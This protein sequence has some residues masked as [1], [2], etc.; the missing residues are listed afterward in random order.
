MIR[1]VVHR[2]VGNVLTTAWSGSILVPLSVI[3]HRRQGTSLSRAYLGKWDGSNSFLRPFVVRMSREGSFPKTSFSDYKVFLQDY[4]AV[5]F[6]DYELDKEN[7]KDAK[8]K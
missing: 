6:L 1:S 4:L 7:I 8:F 3:F 2:S 5:L